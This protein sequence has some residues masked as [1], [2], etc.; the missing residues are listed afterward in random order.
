MAKIN[1]DQG[2]QAL[3]HTMAKVTPQYLTL[4][5]QVRKAIRTQTKRL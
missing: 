5:G 4:L 2:W 3:T 1:S